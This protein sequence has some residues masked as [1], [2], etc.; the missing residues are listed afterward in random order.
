MKEQKIIQVLLALLRSIMH[1]CRRFWKAIS[2]VVIILIVIIGSG[3]SG[4]IYG[5]KVMDFFGMSTKKT[6]SNQVSQAQPELPDVIALVNNEEIRKEEFQK[7]VQLSA[8]SYSAQGVDISLQEAQIQ[9]IENA[10][11]VMINEKIVMQRALRDGISV[12]DEE[13]EKQLSDFIDQLGGR[14][15]FEKSLQSQN[16]T[17]E[18]V[19]NDL[20]RQAIIQKHLEQ[21]VDL[22]SVVVTDEEVAQAYNE[23]V[24][25]Q[26]KPEEAPPLEESFESIK[27]Q[28]IQQKNQAL[29]DKY[30]DSVRQESEIKIMI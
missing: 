26:E 5:D 17:E 13:M 8:Q 24:S 21:S 20:K 19:K 22:G 7:R 30:V 18:Y 25:Q 6:N 28:L 2:F 1:F 14:E 10:I 23:L 29:T 16:L 12:S 11:Q 4:Y 3:I 15:E 27:A 9:I